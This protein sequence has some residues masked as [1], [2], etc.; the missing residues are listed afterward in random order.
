M[1]CA[2]SVSLISSAAIPLSDLWLLTPVVRDKTTAAGTENLICPWYVLPSN[3]AW[4]PNVDSIHAWIWLICDSEVRGA[5]RQTRCTCNVSPKRFRREST[6]P[7]ASMRLARMPARPA[8]ASAS[9]MLC[10]VKRME[11]PGTVS[12]KVR[13][14]MRLAA[15]SSPEEGS[16]SNTTVGLPIKAM[17]R[18][19][20]RLLPPERARAMRSRNCVRPTARMTC[21]TLY[22]MPEAGMPRTRA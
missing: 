12:A 19:S 18:E 22:S 2:V 3:S 6:E 21:S 16:S 17:P 9:S 11:R 14:M 10:V 5:P 15:A 1:L 8:S 7:M 4:L 13:H 20:L